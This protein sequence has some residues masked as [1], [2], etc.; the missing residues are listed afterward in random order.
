MFAW[1][2]GFSP[3]PVPVAVVLLYAAHSTVQCTASFVFPVFA[4]YQAL[5]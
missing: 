5:F 1:M 4:L 2:T 3:V